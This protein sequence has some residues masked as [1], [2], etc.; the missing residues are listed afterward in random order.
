MPSRQP[1]GHIPLY[2]Y[3][4]DPAG[5]FLF[6]SLARFDAL[7]R[8]GAPAVERQALSDSGLVPGRLRTALLFLPAQCRL[9][10]EWN[11]AIEN[12]VLCLPCRTMQLE[13][14]TLP[15]EAAQ[16]LSDAFAAQWNE[17]L[18]AQSFTPQSVR[19]TDGEVVLNA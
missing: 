17:Q 8:R 11:V 6:F 12:G 19:W 13:G 3:I 1:R 5:L 18:E 14:F 7:V 2:Y 9:Y 16:A 4:I 15:G 10:G